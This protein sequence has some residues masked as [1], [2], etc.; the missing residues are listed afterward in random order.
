MLDNHIL[1][2]YHRRVNHNLKGGEQ[3]NYE[4]EEYKTGAKNFTEAVG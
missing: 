3:A 2:L 1:L 4:S